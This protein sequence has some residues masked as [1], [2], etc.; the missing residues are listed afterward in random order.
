MFNLIFFSV[1][2]SQVITPTITAPT[3][4]CQ[5]KVDIGFLLDSSGSITNDY[6]NE[7]DFLKSVVLSFGISQDGSRASVITFS[8]HVEHSIKFKDHTDI[9]SFN[10]AVDAIPLMGSITRIDKALR[11][12]QK[13]MFLAANGART[14]MPKVVV[15]LT[16]GSQTKAPGFESPVKVANELRSS[17]ITLIVVGMGAGVKPRELA[18]VAGGPDKTFTADSFKG[19]LSNGFM[20]SVKAKACE[21]II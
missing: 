1:L 16:D 20:K 10:T 17:G 2:V 8:H 4:T 9:N 18:D 21:G 13:E 3:P 6:Q 12:T 15:L 14:N 5:A 7:K 11:L 19:L